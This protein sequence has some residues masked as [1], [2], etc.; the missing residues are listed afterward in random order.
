MKKYLYFFVFLILQACY[1]DRSQEVEIP[2]EDPPVSMEM[3]SDILVDMHLSQSA[4]KEL[5]AK[6]AN[7][8]GISEEYHALI[9]K[10]YGVSREDF[11]KSLEYYNYRTDDLKAIYEEVITKLS[12]MES[13]LR[14]VQQDT[15]P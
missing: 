12:L 13:E 3:M 6:R 9:L 14:S 8:D 1:N 5:Q 4:I 15:V 11:D 10:K 2:K 7:I